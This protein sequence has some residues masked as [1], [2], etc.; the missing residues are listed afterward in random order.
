MD[1]MDINKAREIK[2]K[3]PD[4]WLDWDVED[5]IADG[6]IRGYESRDAEVEKLKSF[7]FYCLKYSN[8]H[9]IVEKAEKLEESK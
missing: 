3:S 5:F 1:K 8:D 2:I 4:V 6:F 7:V 9:Y